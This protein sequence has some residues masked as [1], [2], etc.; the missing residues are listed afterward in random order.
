MGGCNPP[1]SGSAIFWVITKFFNINQFQFVGNMLLSQLDEQ[2]FR[3]LSKTSL[4]K[5]VLDPI[6]TLVCMLMPYYYY[7][8]SFFCLSGQLKR[9]W[10]CALSVVEPTAPKH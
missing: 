4:G 5:E 6:E 7:H 8:Y 2:F 9:T 1:E 3:A 10:D